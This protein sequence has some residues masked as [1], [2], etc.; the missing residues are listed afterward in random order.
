MWFKDLM[1]FDELNPDQVR[2]NIMIDGTS[3]TSKV[4]GKR[5]IFGRLETV[6]LVSQVFGSALPVR[7]S[8]ISQNMSE[9][10]AQLILASAY[11]TISRR[12]LN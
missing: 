8:G 6:S 10:F 2:E 4:N 7:Y 11:A 3:M 12:A 5:Y 1:G 9:E